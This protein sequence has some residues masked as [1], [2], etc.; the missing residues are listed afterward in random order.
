MDVSNAIY[1]NW[2]NIPK[3]ERSKIIVM[4]MRSQKVLII[5]AASFQHHW[6]DLQT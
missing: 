4:M 1:D 5:K 3:A 2:M 6:T